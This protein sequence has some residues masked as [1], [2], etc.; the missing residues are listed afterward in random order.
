MKARQDWTV[1][2]ILNETEGD[3]TS[4]RPWYESGDIVELI[5]GALVR[6]GKMRDLEVQTVLARPDETRYYQ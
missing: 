2:I 1:T 6:N 5:R 3:E 4:T